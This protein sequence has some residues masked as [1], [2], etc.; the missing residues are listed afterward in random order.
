VTLLLSDLLAEWAEHALAWDDRDGAWVSV[1]V[2]NDAPNQSLYANY[3]KWLEQQGRNTRPLALKSFKAKLVDL[4]RDTLGLP[5]PGGFTNT[6][7]YRERG[8]GSVIPSLRLRLSFEEGAGLIRYAF[9]RRAEVLEAERVETDP[10]RNGNGKTQVRKRWNGWN[11][12]ETLNHKEK[13]KAESSS[14]IGE[15]TAGSVPAVPPIP[16]S[17]AQRSASI[18]DAG[19]SVP[20]SVQSQLQSLKPALVGS[21]ADVFGDDDDPAWGPRQEVA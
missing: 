12:S 1:G 6:G 17:G 5:L 19:R 4:L 3:L 11:G 16:Q 2:A 18:P 13:N 7:Q 8:V 14:S 9:M 20:G 10:E 15:V 21:G